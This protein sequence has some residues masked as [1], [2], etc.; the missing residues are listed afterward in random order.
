MLESQSELAAA[1]N[2]LEDLKREKEILSQE[3][4]LRAA[5]RTPLDMRYQET[6]TDT[7]RHKEERI[8]ILETRLEEALFQMNA[9]K[10]Q[11]ISL[12]RNV[13]CSQPNLRLAEISFSSLAQPR[14]E[15]Q[16]P[17]RTPQR[18][19]SVSSAA[20]YARIKQERDKANR[21]RFTPSPEL[22]SPPAVRR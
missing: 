7:I 15:Q 11:N 12:S 13:S 20:Y 22:G 21:G 10:E 3:A 2:D 8:R 5:R 9:L 19:H 16:S 4:E 6:Y 18:T 17:R 14:E 1:R